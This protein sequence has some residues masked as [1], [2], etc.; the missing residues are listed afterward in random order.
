MTALALGLSLQDADGP[1]MPRQAMDAIRRNNGS[2][3]LPGAA[4]PVLG[5]ELVVLGAQ[6]QAN[7]VDLSLDGTVTVSG[8][9]YLV[10]LPSGCYINF[11]PGWTTTGGLGT[12][13]FVV[14]VADGAS[15]LIL[16]S[17]G[18]TISAGTNGSGT[19]TLSGT[20]VQIN[21]AL[22]T[23]SYQGNLNYHGSDTLTM[24][25]T[26]SAGTSLSDSD[27][28]AIV[29]NPVNDAPGINAP[30]TTVEALEVTEDRT[31]SFTGATLI[32][33]SDVDGTVS[34]V[35]VS[36][37]HYPDR[38]S[39]SDQY[40][41]GIPDLYKQRQLQRFRHAEYRCNR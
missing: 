24:L 14:R 39:V 27:T 11:G 21:A 8:R 12:G 4:T 34:S 2:L 17:S 36:V 29:I 10:Y 7:G 37:S 3:I 26:D 16:N 15:P 6:S 19:L 40:G 25:S 23:L 22:A 13:A 9:S 35:S 41:I 38:Y 32:S 30:D 18:A 5:G 20:Q 33:A 1:T 28:V 31:L